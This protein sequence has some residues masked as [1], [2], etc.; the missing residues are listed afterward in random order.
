MDGNNRQALD[1]IISCLL[2]NKVD[3]GIFFSSSLRRIAT[4]TLP[5]VDYAF[6]DLASGKTVAIIFYDDNSD[7]SKIK[8]C[9]IKALNSFDAV[10]A[11]FEMQYMSESNA[12]K[13][14]LTADRLLSLPIGIVVY[15]SSGNV[16]VIHKF[17]ISQNQALKRTIKEQKSYWCW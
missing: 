13:D 4:W 10:I 2:A 14:S 15:D 8:A 12:F 5:F 16:A 17:S 7:E 11:A 9:A 6:Q 3:N 1:S